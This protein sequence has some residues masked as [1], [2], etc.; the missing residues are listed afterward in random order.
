MKPKKIMLDQYHLDIYIRPNRTL[1]TQNRQKI[2]RLMRTFL[3]IAAASVTEEL[4]NKI[5]VKI[6][7]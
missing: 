6:T 3:S 2:K 7:Q 1:S 5:E 4:E